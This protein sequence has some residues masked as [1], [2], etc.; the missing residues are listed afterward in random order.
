MRPS[1]RSHPRL[2]YCRA[3]AAALVATLGCAAD[4]QPRDA[5]EHPRIRHG[6]DDVATPQSNASV[7][8][9]NAADALCTGTLITPTRV[10]TAN[11]CLTA[12]ED[13]KP[14]LWGPPETTSPYGTKWAV[15]KGSKPIS[16]GVGLYTSEHPTHTAT[17]I[18]GWLRDTVSWTPELMGRDIAV[19][20]LDRRMPIGTGPGLWNIVPVHAWEPGMTCP[21]E[22]SGRYTGWGRLDKPGERA[23]TRQAYESDIDCED[24]LCETSFLFDDY[25]GT[26]R[27]DSGGPLFNKTS[28]PLVCGVASGASEYHSYWAQTDAPDNHD[29]IYDTAWSSKSGTWEGE[30]GGA[31][32]DGDLVGADCDNCP[33]VFN[34]TQ[35]NS[36]GDW[37]GDHCDNCRLIANPDQRNSNQPAEREAYAKAFLGGVEPPRDDV[38]LETYFP[39]DVCDPYPQTRLTASYD[40]FD[41]TRP[42]GRRIPCE[43]SREPICGGWPSAGD[44]GVSYGNVIVAE[45]FVG[46]GAD[47][48]GITRMMTCSCAS[49]DPSVCALSYGCNRDSVGMPWGWRSM[50]LTDLATGT[51]VTDGSGRLATT[52]PSLTKTTTPISP[53]PRRLGWNYWA[54][55]SLAPVMPGAAYGVFDGLA[56]AWVATHWNSV[57][58]PP[59]PGTVT[60]TEAEQRRRQNFARITVDEVAT[61][62]L[63]LP[64]DTIPW[65]KVPLVDPYVDPFDLPCSD[66][67]DADDG[68]FTG[69]PHDPMGG[70]EV[71]LL[72]G[73][74][75]VRGG[76]DVIDHELVMQLRDPAMVP[77]FAGDAAGAAHGGAIGAFFDIGGRL[78]FVV[79]GDGLVHVEPA[80]YSEPQVPTQAPVVAAMSAR[81]QELAVFERDVQGQPMLRTIDLDTGATE[82]ERFIGDV[83]PE[84]VLALAYNAHDDA[85]YAIER[86]GGQF[87]ARIL[88]F[89]RGRTVEIVGAWPDAHAFESL[90]LTIGPRGELVVTSSAPWH[91]V[92]SVLSF[93]ESGV[94]LWAQEH[95]QDML[96]SPAHAT[97]HGVYWIGAMPQSAPAAH[98]VAVGEQELDIRAMEAAF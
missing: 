59:S 8:L 7:R 89:P 84:Q 67:T 52:H 26:L 78:M 46:T 79:R 85:Y 66:C 40:R 61:P 63:P 64:C 6:W 91:V 51:I 39:G 45:S 30:C 69:I 62:S 56:W 1:V 38:Y 58:S 90:A 15:A 31:D 74:G 88:R 22:F 16:I 48:D 71:L 27:G 50:T 25:R 4:E 37:R 17:A 87:G 70:D 12:G 24:S 34:P 76:G 93:D 57:G 21:D 55:L 97:S 11:H 47:Q 82:Y 44:C 94:H 42:D 77:V 41:D 13:G 53:T 54:D 81:R 36:D 73:E 29:F 35:V 23:T 96:A 33:D 14:G 5:G 49:S 60:G 80:P 72:A 95:A 68:W 20:E 9:T 2:R 98:R 75:G 43:F 19:L 32:P 28:P 18:R 83:R 10:L 92:V 86:N 65:F 3:S